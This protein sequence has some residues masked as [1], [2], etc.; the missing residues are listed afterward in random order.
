[1]LNDKWL[2][3]VVVHEF[4]HA[5]ANP[6]AEKWYAENEMFRSWC[7]NMNF[8]KV[9]EYAPVGITMA[10][11]YLTRAYTIL[12][13]VEN[14]NGNLPQLLLGEEGRFPHIKQVYEIIKSNTEPK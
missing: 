11:E 8:E 4:S 3:S 12:Y 14:D 2:K 9:P 5:F 6:I 13:A 1:V 7:D 10:G